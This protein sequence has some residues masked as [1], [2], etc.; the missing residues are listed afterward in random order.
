MNKYYEVGFFKNE[1]NQFQACSLEA[2]E[3][4]NDYDKVIKVEF[5]EMFVGTYEEMRKHI[6]KLARQIFEAK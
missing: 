4:H 3:N 6:I 5:N 2:G 1:F